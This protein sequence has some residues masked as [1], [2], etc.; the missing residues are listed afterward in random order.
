MWANAGEGA[1]LVSANRRDRKTEFVKIYAERTG[2]C[3]LETDMRPPLS[4]T[5]AFIEL[6]PVLGVRA[7]R[8]CFWH[9][10]IDAL[11]KTHYAKYFLVLCRITFLVARNACAGLGPQLMATASSMRWSAGCSLGRS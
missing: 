3:V 7:R 8:N 4:T 2:P 5:P 6:R 1:F 11:Y 9:K 10:K